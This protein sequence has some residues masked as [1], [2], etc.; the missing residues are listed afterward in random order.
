M[1]GWETKD[2][3]CRQIEQLFQKNSRRH[4]QCKNAVC[5]A[6][7]FTAARNFS[8]QPCRAPLSARKERPAD[9]PATPAECTNLESTQRR[10]KATSDT[11]NSARTFCAA[12]LGRDARQNA[13]VMTRKRGGESK[14]TE[15]KAVFCFILD[16]APG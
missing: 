12:S 15:Q 16:R 1:V 2:Q 4:H 8:V 11:A 14:T 13:A 3:N 9:T 7:E 10:E 5:T 6:G